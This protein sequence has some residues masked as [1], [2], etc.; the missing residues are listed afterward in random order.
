MTEEGRGL[1]SWY[2][3]GKGTREEH[4]KNRTGRPL[5]GAVSRTRPEAGRL[6]QQLTREMHWALIWGGMLMV[7][8]PL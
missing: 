6:D 3:W 8:A 4:Q 7:M 1:S 5:T 2:S